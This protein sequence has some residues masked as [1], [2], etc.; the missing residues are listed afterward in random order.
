MTTRQFDMR[1]R[2]S[3]RSLAPTLALMLAIAHQ[4]LAADVQVTAG[5]YYTCAWV[6]NDVAKCWGLNASGQ[7]GQGDPTTRGTAAGQLGSALPAINFGTGR[8]A[9]RIAAGSFHACALLDNGRVKCWGDNGVGQ[10]GLGLG[11]T[12]PRG[13]LANQ[14]GDFLPAVDLGTDPN[15]LLPYTATRIAAG[16]TH[17]CA[18]LSN[19]QVKCWGYNAYGQLGLGDTTQRGD[20]VGSMGDALPAVDLGSDPLTG[21][22]YGAKEIGAIGYQTCAKLDNDEL[23]CWGDNRH[24]QLGQG[25]IDPRGVAPLQMG[26]L[27]A[28]V[29]LGPARSARWVAGGAYHLCA[30]LDDASVKC[31]G[32][33]LAGQLGLGDADDRGDAKGEMAGSLLAIDLGS[34]LGATAVAGGYLHSCALLG[35]A[36]VKCW[37]ANDRGQ[38]GQGDTAYRGNLPGQM[39]DTLLPIDFGVGRTAVRI[40]AGVSH[41]CAVLDNATLKCWGL[42]NYGQLGQGDALNR[43]FA[44]GQMGDALLAIDLG[45]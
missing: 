45:F 10:L 32:Y 12:L 7:L 4:A 44:A 5:D 3:A 20:A 9:S 36:S 38:L 29:K 14:M 26:N 22:A 37:G 16:A 39:G 31:W 15:T 35:N 2:C 18:L 28:R 19:R 42:N 6:K 27:L 13:N 30:V 8:T 34:G 17:S 11:D 25:D 43:G 21:V 23:K 1:L 33:N 41:A 40:A 24:G